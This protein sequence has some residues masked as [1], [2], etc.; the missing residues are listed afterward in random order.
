M[1]FIHK[2]SVQLIFQP[3]LCVAQVSHD[4]YVFL[5]FLL[6]VVGNVLKGFSDE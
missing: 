2:R 6:K 4:A 1:H 5:F 3:C